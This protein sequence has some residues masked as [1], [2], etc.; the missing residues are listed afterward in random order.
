MPLVDKDY[1]VLDWHISHTYNVSRNAHQFF[2]K[3][4]RTLFLSPLLFRLCGKWNG[5]WLRHVSSAK[6]K[7]KSDVMIKP[8]LIF[9]LFSATVNE[10]GLTQRF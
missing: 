6:N 4:E 9:R 3:C 5:Y 1:V 2:W 8:H 7:R 10:V